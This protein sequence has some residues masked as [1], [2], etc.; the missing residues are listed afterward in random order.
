M[1]HTHHHNMVTSFRFHYCPFVVHVLRVVYFLSPLVDWV[2]VFLLLS[3]SSSL[4]AEIFVCS[5]SY[6]SQNDSH[7]KKLATNSGRHVDK[8]EC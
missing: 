1:G 4:Y 5:R 6:S 3:L 7:K 8:K 2:I